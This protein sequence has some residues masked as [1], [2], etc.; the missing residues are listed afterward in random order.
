MKDAKSLTTSMHASA[1]AQGESLVHV[2]GKHAFQAKR[3]GSQ[4]WFY[5]DDKRYER[6]SIEGWMQKAIEAE[7]AE[8][9]ELFGD[10]SQFTETTAFASVRA[11]RD[12]LYKLADVEQPV[13][14]LI[15]THLVRIGYD[16]AP[17]GTH[18]VTVVNT[19]E[20][21]HIDIEALPNINKTFGKFGSKDSVLFRGL[22]MT[23]AAFDGGPLVMLDEA[24]IIDPPRKPL[25]LYLQLLGRGKRVDRESRYVGKARNKQTAHMLVIAEKLDEAL[26][27]RKI[28]PTAVKRIR[29]LN[30][31]LRILLK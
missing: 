10:G 4:V 13:P 8:I 14:K 6:A 20:G 2:I 17:T 11:P 23:H 24:H 18:S 5:M 15:D 21:T 9:D 19:G 28:T 25:G 16:W 29:R 12:G 1:K 3:H 7:T 30:R 22:E 31:I 26:L 27:H